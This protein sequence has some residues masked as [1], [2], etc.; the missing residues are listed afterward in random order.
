MKITCIQCGQEFQSKPAPCPSD[1]GDRGFEC[2]VAHLDSN[3]FI[4]ACGYDN[5]PQVGEAFQEGTFILPGV[6]IVSNQETKGESVKDFT[7]IGLLGPAGSGKDLVADW[8]ATKGFVKVA[9]ADP[10]KRFVMRTFGIDQERL[11]GPSD[12]RNEVFPVEDTWWFEAIGH[13]GNAATE[14]VNDVLQEGTKVTGYLKLHEWMTKLRSDYRN[15][16]SARVIL[17]TLGTEWGREIDPLMWAR[18]AHKVVRDLR[19]LGDN[20]AYSQ[21]Q[22]VASV[23]RGGFSGVVI[24]DHRFLNEVQCTHENGGFVFRLRRLSMENAPTVGIEGHKSEAEQKELS[25]DLFDV[26][27]NF[28]EGIDKVHEQLEDVFAGKSWEHPH[29]VSV[30]HTPVSPSVE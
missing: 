19:D 1:H 22:G 9:F 8:M 25:D 12:K 13:L 11:W 26:V 24:P 21:Y 28:P 23:P 17:Q 27:F 10:M 18:Y 30:C 7:V 5:G 14:I 20:A 2:P 4:C 16:I 29:G 6:S 15:E 3:S